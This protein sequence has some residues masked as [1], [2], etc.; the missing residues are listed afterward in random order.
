MDN[1]SKFDEH[2]RELE[3]EENSIHFAPLKIDITDYTE[4]IEFDQFVIRRMSDI[5]ISKFLGIKKAT[6]DEDGRPGDIELYNNSS[7][8]YET[9]PRF[10]FGALYLIELKNSKAFDKVD[11]LLVAFK[12]WKSG[13]VFAPMAYSESMKSTMYSLPEHTNYDFILRIKQE[14]IPDILAI[15][16]LIE[17]SKN[18]KTKLMLER[19]NNAIAST[20]SLVNTFVELVSIIESILVSEPYE[21]RFRLS[22]Y[23]TYILNNEFSYNITVK[24]MQSFYDI[25]S[26]LLHTG[27]SSKFSKDCLLQLVEITILMIRWHLKSGEKEGYA[28]KLIYNKLEIE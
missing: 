5:E 22:L 17:N 24:E 6:I 20:T 13:D 14:E 19:F 16:R 23:S 1:T 18:Q 28:K 25:R 3:L 2:L 21:L 7:Y 27:D 26:K 11:N 4:Q 12:L 9:L 15:Y 8:H 10:M